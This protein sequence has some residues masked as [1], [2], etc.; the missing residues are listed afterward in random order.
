M[1]LKLVR[2][3]AN[4]EINEYWYVA[5]ICMHQ[6]VILNSLDA[7]ASTIEVYL[8]IVNYDI[9]VSDDGSFSDGTL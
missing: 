3:I 4:F 2:F 9:T 7:D 5:D 6:L 8:D 1:L